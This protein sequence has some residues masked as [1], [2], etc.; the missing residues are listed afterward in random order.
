[1]QKENEKP[2]KNWII[3][4]SIGAGVALIAIVIIIII[5]VIKKRKVKKNEDV[6][7]ISGSD[8]V[9]NLAEIKD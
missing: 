6:Q 5:I 1:M 4:V 7:M 2:N 3:Y 9:I 8:I